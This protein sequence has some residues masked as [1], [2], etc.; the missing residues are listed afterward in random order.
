M[1]LDQ[2]ENRKAKLIKIVL[3]WS[4]FI[5]IVFL[6]KR[7]FKP[8]SDN[9]DFVVKNLASFFCAIILTGVMAKFFDNK[10]MII[11]IPIIWLLTFLLLL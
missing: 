10:I 6:N 8:P 9:I 2:K 11:C 7:L 5:L 4:N 1:S 3:F